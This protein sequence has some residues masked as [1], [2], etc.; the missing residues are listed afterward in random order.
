MYGR[1]HPDGEKVLR[2]AV[3]LQ[4]EAIGRKLWSDSYGSFNKV[5]PLFVFLAIL[6][7]EKASEA[8]KLL[9][10]RKPP[11][12]L[13][14]VLDKHM[15][16][17]EP[18]ISFVKTS[19]MLNRATSLANGRYI[20]SVDLLLA[21]AEVDNM[22]YS[23][24]HSMFGL[25]RI[26]L[27]R[28]F[29]QWEKERGHLFMDKGD[30]KNTF[31]DAFMDDD[32]DEDI[33]NDEPYY[34]DDD[35]E[36]EDMNERPGRPAIRRMPS[37]KKD[38]LES[39]L[40]FITSFGRDLTEEAR[41]GKLEPLIGRK[42][43]V[44][45]L[46]EILGRR[47]KSNPLIIGNPGVGK[48]MIVHGLASRIAYGEVPDYLKDAHV[49]ELAT[50]A[51]VAG[52]K[53]RG[54][55]EDRIKKI[56]DLA[57]KYRDHI[58]LFFD[59]IHTLIGA[60][61]AEGALDAAN[62][63]KPALAS[64]QLRVIGATTYE[65]YKK[66][67]EKDSALVR[68]F[69]LVH[70]DEPTV[71]ETKEILLGT[72]HLYESHYNIHIPPALLE[73]VVK[74]SKR[75]ISSRYLPDK[76]VDVLDRAC[77]RASLEY[78]SLEDSYRCLGSMAGREDEAFF[79]ASYADFQE[80]HMELSYISDKL[81]H[82]GEAT[83]RIDHV[84]DVISDMS[85][86]PVSR[87]SDD[88]V[89]MLRNLESLL[90][91][92][93]VGQ[94]E[95]IKKVAKAVRRGRLGIRNQNRPV[96]VFLFMGPTGV[97]KTELARALA[98]VVYG[99]EDNMIRLDMSEY[100]EQHSVSKLFGSPPGYVGYGEGG[101]LT[102]A[103]RQKPYSLIL[104]DE[105]EKAHPRVWDTFLQVFEDGFMTDGQGRRVDFR[106]TIIIMTSNVG[107]EK[108][109]EARM[110]FV[111]DS[112][113]E[114]N[115][116]LAGELKKTFRPEFLNRIDSVVFFKPLSK[117]DMREILYITISK[118]KSA[119]DEKEIRFRLT[120]RMEDHL[121]EKGFDP[122][123]GARPIRRALDEYL[124][125][126]IVDYYLEHGED[127]IAGKM[128]VIDWDPE[129]QDVIIKIDENDSDSGSDG[130]IRHPMEV[131]EVTHTKV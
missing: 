66:R 14:F 46:I 16:T 78:L 42:K 27:E 32:D 109:K 19:E 76:A 25:D 62:I 10:K 120:R 82:K 9:L 77:G 65:D 31:F 91:T 110:G 92:R 71:E 8:G 115:E 54:E 87:I 97:G 29:R 88:E 105:V 35:D 3:E 81:A 74:L 44:L 11:T 96:A 131:G 68:R 55:F 73:P 47:I 64:G 39:A 72:L 45:E 111:G 26:E 79:T 21:A 52:T 57:V 127:T 129:K 24:L 130:Q 83:L 51:I 122:E 80:K 106:N 20:T 30:E 86:V 7:L 4:N 28:M 53:Y 101:Q 124:F 58:V 98:E 38:T 100:M 125:N 56:I 104:L 84:L 102:E 12:I 41:Q 108:L 48:T 107:A 22:V 1:F 112:S 69:V 95:A 70:I 5:S 13:R 6:K 60:G 36:I 126:P 103:I 23:V 15:R 40:K 118:Y 33:I 43:E 50:S 121:L 18:H 93:V 94:D 113:K 61:S 63:L 123:F 2:K 85:G 34:E 37:K 59:E 89:K 128:L 75:Y 67:F 119:L 90:K 114:I 117:E 17:R 116:I 49:I 99:S